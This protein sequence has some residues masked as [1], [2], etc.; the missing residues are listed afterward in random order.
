MKTHQ[1]LERHKPHN[2]SSREAKVS[3]EGKYQSVLPVHPG[4]EVLRRKSSTVILPQHQA[5]AS[6]GYLALPGRGLEH[7]SSWGKPIK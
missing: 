4:L 1:F 6:H 3:L 7:S 5:A 2:T